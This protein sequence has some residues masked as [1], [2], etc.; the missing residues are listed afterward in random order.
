MLLNCRLACLILSTFDIST[1]L[2]VKFGLA[3]P[4]LHVAKRVLCV[5]CYVSAVL[6][7][8]GVLEEGQGWCSAYVK[9]RTAATPP[10]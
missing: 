2:P 5:F 6:E 8:R 4:A 9:V 7:A 10:T 1:R 3:V